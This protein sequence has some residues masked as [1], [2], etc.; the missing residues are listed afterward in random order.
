MDNDNLQNA[1]GCDSVGKL[2]LTINYSNTGTDVSTA[3]DRK[4]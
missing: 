1:A 3:C 2:D 4:K